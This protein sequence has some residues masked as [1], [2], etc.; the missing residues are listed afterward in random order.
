VIAAPG[1]CSEVLTSRRMAGLLGFGT[2][3]RSRSAGCAHIYAAGRST[4]N[5]RCSHKAEVVL[6]LS[7]SNDNVTKQPLFTHIRTEQHQIQSNTAKLKGGA[8]S[9]LF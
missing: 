8:I 4:Q 9:G 7:R 2:T 6:L 1:S 3:R 5:N